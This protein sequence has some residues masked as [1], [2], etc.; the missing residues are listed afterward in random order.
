MGLAT[1]K[2]HA[3]QVAYIVPA[4]KGRESFLCL[5]SSVRAVLAFTCAGLSYTLLYTASLCISNAWLCRPLFCAGNCCGLHCQRSASSTTAGVLTPLLWSHACLSQR[6]ALHAGNSYPALDGS[7]NRPGFCYDT[8]LLLPEFNPMAVPM[9]AADSAGS[10]GLVASPLT[11]VL[12]F[13]QASGTDNTSAFITCCTNPY[14]LFKPEA[15]NV[16]LITQHVLLQAK[17]LSIPDMR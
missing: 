6:A 11:T 8:A 13:S 9:P 15:S 4:A 14:G 3:G 2:V 1:A 12:V 16:L 17:G 5:L 10:S 7:T